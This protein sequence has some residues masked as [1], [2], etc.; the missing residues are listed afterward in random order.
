MAFSEQSNNEKSVRRVCKSDRCA[1]VNFFIDGHNKSG[2]AINAA[3]ISGGSI[4][5]IWADRNSGVKFV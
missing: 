4:L 5:R 2:P 1:G 3:F